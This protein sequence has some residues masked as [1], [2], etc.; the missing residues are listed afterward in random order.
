MTPDLP[1]GLWKKLTSTVGLVSVRHGTGTNVMAAEW[2]YFVNKAPLYAA[3]VLGPRAATGALIAGAGEFSLTLCAEDQAE[4]AD[5]AGSF[6]VADVDKTGSE[7]IA[8]GEPEATGSP[9]VTGGLVAV[10]CV[11]RQTVNF[12]VHTMYVGEVVAAHLPA[13]P[14]RP[15]VKHGAMHTLG[16]PVRRTAVVATARSLP[17]GL[18][19]IAA[20]GPV[21][22][23]DGRWRVSLLTAGGVTEPLG[24]HPT[25]VYGDFLVDL[26]VPDH[27]P[28]ERLGGC[29]VRVE[30]DGADP[31]YAEITGA[32]PLPGVRE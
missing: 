12:P 7:L 13:H 1:D 32:P 4:V 8:F 27:L 22:A 25:G 21:G 28:V 14:P 19:R 10:E 26:P 17:G 30:R 9:W 20:T 16:A 6:S 29:R 24:D 11:L 2:S 23:E 18:L 15:L 5:F 3:V 31:G